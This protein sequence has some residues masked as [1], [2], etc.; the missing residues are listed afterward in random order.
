MKKILV[1]E[2]DLNIYGIYAEALEAQGYQVSNVNNGAQAMNAIRDQMPDLVILDLVMP[3]RNGLDILKEIR[4]D[5]SLE[6]IKVVVTTNFGNENNVSTALDLGANDY[7]MKYNVGAEEL[8]KKIATLL[9]DIQG[10]GISM[11]G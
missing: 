10:A 7:I 8:S 3:G 4:D 1:L 2:D 11:V 6:K 5:S 9:G